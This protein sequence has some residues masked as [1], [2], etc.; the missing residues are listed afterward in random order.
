MEVQ[1]LPGRPAANPPRLFDF[2]FFAGAVDEAGVLECDDLCGKACRGNQSKDEEALRKAN[3]PVS[4]VVNGHSV[5][6]G[7]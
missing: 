3:V 5:L 6:G 7:F 4:R 2:S 1:I